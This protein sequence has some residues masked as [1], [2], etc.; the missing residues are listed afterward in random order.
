MHEVYTEQLCV[1]KH[2]KEINLFHNLKSIPDTE[3]FKL[4]GTFLV[5]KLYIE[6]MISH[7]DEL[8][9]TENYTWTFQHFSK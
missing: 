9:I 4:I 1:Q 8:Q 6:T 5:F 2:E 7:V 3:A